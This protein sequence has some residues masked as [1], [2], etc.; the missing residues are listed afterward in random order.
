MSGSAEIRSSLHPVIPNPRAGAFLFLIALSF[1]AVATTPGSKL[2][3]VSRGSLCVTE[4]AI[5]ELPGARL[6]VSVPKMRAYLNAPTPPV[7]EAQF[8]YLGS[9]VRE[10]R[11]GS[12]ELRRQF[13][14]KLRAQ[15]ACNLV[16]A[17]WRI[18]P[19]SRLV[20]SVK[21]NPGEHTS[22]QCGNRGYRNIKPRRS[23][24][25]PTLR[26]GDA[27]SLRAEMNGAALAV[28]I[29]NVIVWEGSV[30]T[31]ALVFD[32]PVGIRSDNARLQIA[33]RAARPLEAQSTH[34]PGCRSAPE[35]S[36]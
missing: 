24:P 13:G 17:M 7:V 6:D 26:P 30:G 18:E 5:S 11:L 27:H 32:G 21:S 23:A 2:M 16:Y 1:T 12:G 28:F 4:G 22:T 31:D 9:T 14:L 15:D 10:V 3:L 20:V 25:V 8:T 29:D 33:L 36:E 19:E 34:P 35:E